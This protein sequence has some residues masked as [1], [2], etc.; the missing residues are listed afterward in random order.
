MWPVYTR[1]CSLDIRTGTWDIYGP[2]TG[3][4]WGSA[5]SLIGPTGPAATVASQS[6]VNTGTDAALP[7]SLAGT[8]WTLNTG[9]APGM[10]VRKA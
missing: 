10:I 2:K 6:E 5:T 3:G 7:S 9:A 8:S 4:S 1:W